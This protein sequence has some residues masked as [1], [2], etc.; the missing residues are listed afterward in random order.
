[1]SKQAYQYS[2][3][4]NAS[5]IQPVYRT[6]SSLILSSNH[7]TINTPATLKSKSPG[8]NYPS[9]AVFL[10]YLRDSSSSEQGNPVLYGVDDV[11]DYGEDEEE[12]D[13]YD[14]DD[15]VALDHCLESWVKRGE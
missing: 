10:F 11:A 4:G 1:M 5:H 14:G 8:I 15:E 7:H 13:D 12:E 2:A 3:P 9:S 6:L